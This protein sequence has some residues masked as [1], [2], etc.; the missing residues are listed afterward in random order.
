MLNLYKEQYILLNI[1]HQIVGYNSTVSIPSHLIEREFNITNFLIPIIIVSFSLITLAKYRNTRIIIILS[2]L[3]LSSKNLE[4]VLKEEMRI[5]SI[6]SVALLIN[7]FIVFN[8][9]LFLTSYHIL[10]QSTPQSILYSLIISISFISL[11]II[12]LWLVGII[13]GENKSINIPITETVILY[14]TFGIILFFVALCWMLNPHLSV[15]FLKVFGGIILLEMIVRFS[16][17]VLSVL[18]R[19][20]VW[21][22]IILYLCTL[23]IL[24]LVVVYLYLKVNFDY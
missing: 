13:S 9:C 10:H 24:P 2:K 21:Y 5:N 12:G 22:Y 23:E 15:L 16:K 7:Y 1:A 14:E 18:K 17:C 11:Q 20:V 4:Y 19:G 6:S 3:F 8:A